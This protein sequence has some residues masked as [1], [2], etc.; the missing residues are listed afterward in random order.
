MNDNL[1]LLWQYLL[2]HHL[3][4]R[5][6]GWLAHCRW[7]WVKKTFIRYFIDYFQVD[8]QLA[9]QPD[10][11]QYPT[12]NDF[13]TREL[14]PGIRPIAPGEDIITS[15][16]DGKI[17][18]FGLVE[19]GRLIQAKGFDFSLVE[20]LSEESLAKPFQ[21]GK[22]VTFYLAPKDYHRIHMPL[23]GKLEQMV[24]VPGQLF[25][26]NDRS[27]RQIPRLFARN[28]RVIAFFDTNLGPM[29]MVLV[30]AM[31]VAS[32]ETTWAGLIAPSRKPGI[33][34]WRYYGNEMMLQKGDE[35]GRFQ[36]GSTVITIFADPHIQWNQS[37]ALSR[38]VILGQALV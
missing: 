35:M 36:L 25:S 37:V 8:M 5:I 9:K 14:R 33:Q 27:A 11:T 32:I 10:P 21:H 34:K 16:V 30:G 7:K 13:F 31:I 19:N 15:P 24:Y 4:S 26:V 28:E 2:P 6:V 38:Q 1:A 22:F 3:L 17:S 18:Q 29:A 20:L 12:F 23:T